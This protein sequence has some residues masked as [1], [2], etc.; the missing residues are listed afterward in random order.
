VFAVNEVDFSASDGGYLN[1]D[2]E[3]LKDE[4]KQLKLEKWI[5]N[6]IEEHIY[7]NNVLVARR[8]VK[9]TTKKA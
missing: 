5:L 1:L 9:K 6:T 7:K 4:L 2:I 3:L 8:I